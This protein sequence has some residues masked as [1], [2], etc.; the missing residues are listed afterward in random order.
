[1]YRK[2]LT[3]WMRK[4]GKSYSGQGTSKFD[5]PKSHYWKRS[6][7]IWDQYSRQRPNW[8][9]LCQASDLIVREWELQRISY[10]EVS[11]SHFVFLK[12]HLQN[13]D[14]K[15]MHI[16]AHLC[17]NTVYTFVLMLFLTSSVYESHTCSKP[18]GLPI[19]LKEW[20]CSSTPKPIFGFSLLS[21]TPACTGV[22]DIPVTQ[23]ALSLPSGPF[24]FRFFCLEWSPK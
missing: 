20:S 13:V 7:V 9:R 15:A 1:M 22:L 2:S 3:A 18:P 5:S 19:S 17:L 24:H 14:C 4:E 11:W 23:E 21:S 16:I 10:K 6:S 12:I 8:R